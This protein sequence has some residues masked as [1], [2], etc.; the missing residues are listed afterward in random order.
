MIAQKLGLEQYQHE[1][2][3]LT[4]FLYYLLVVSSVIAPTYEEHLLGL[5][6]IGAAKPM[7]FI[8]TGDW[9]PLSTTA[10]TQACDESSIWQSHLQLG[11]MLCT[12]ASV[13]WL[14]H[15]DRRKSWRTSPQISVDSKIHPDEQQPFHN[16]GSVVASMLG[17]EP[18]T[19]AEAEAYGA[20]LRPRRTARFRAIVRPQATRVFLTC[21]Q[22]EISSEMEAKY[23]QYNQFSLLER[24]K[25]LACTALPLS[26]MFQLSFIFNSL[27]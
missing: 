13:N 26:V 24:F 22:T 5:I 16:D 8:I 2:I 6:I 11:I 19:S 12:S 27:S 17:W 14:S 15:A 4:I 9:C 21:S 23:Q 7:A 25:P 3:S 10:K 20:L 18:I 1:I